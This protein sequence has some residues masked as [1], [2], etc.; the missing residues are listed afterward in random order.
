MDARRVAIVPTATSVT[1]DVAAQV[2]AAIQR[3]I[4]EDFTPWW[5][6]AGNVVAFAKLEDVP[7][8]YFV[9]QL[10]GS[11]TQPGI[12]GFHY[13]DQ[14]GEPHALVRVDHEHWSMAVS[15]ECLEMIA[16]PSGS[17]TR[18]APPPGQSAG[19][20][21]YLQEVCDPCQHFNYGYELNGIAVSDFYGPDYFD[22]Q[23]K[24]GDQYCITGKLP[25]PRTVLPGGYLSYRD[26]GGVWRK[27]LN[28]DNQETTIVVGQPAEMAGAS[29]RE[30]IDSHSRKLSHAD[31]LRDLGT[32]HHAKTIERADHLKRQGEERRRF[33]ISRAKFYKAVLSSANRK[34]PVIVKSAK[35]RRLF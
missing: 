22:A 4:T 21:E 12:E 16:D 32:K 29:Y 30:W 20:V 7:H 31:T 2:A 1:L 17:L 13:L 11:L 19:A 8:D 33:A 9:I 28:I 6:I 23:T 3:Q 24:A 18:T 25:G 26:A 14:L 35:R 10:V 34:K 5:G 27:L 15:H